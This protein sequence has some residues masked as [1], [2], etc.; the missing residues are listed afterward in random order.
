MLQVF[1]QYRVLSQNQEN[2]RLRFRENFET[3]FNVG[4]SLASYAV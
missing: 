1:M 4:C 2:I 3:V